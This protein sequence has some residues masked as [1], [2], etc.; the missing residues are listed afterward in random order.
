MT[1]NEVIAP[2]PVSVRII[3]KVRGLIAMA[4]SSEFPEEREAF[5]GKAQEMISRY[6][7]DAALLRDADPLAAT[8]PTQRN[9]EV[10]GK[11]SAARGSLINVVARA[12]GVKCIRLGGRKGPNGGQLYDLIGFESD[13]DMVEFLFVELDLYL[14]RE[15]SNARPDVIDNDDAPRWYRQESVQSYRASFAL[16]FAARIDER[17][18]VAKAAAEAAAKAEEATAPVV[19]TVGV[20][21]ALRNKDA[22]VAQ[23]YAKAYPRTSHIRRT[24]GSRS[25]YGAGSS[26]ANGANLNRSKAIR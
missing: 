22:A 6:E 5:F 16:G 20:A 24:V 23:A 18:T 1:T 13:I 21:L 25:G 19:R 14:A 4:N 11:Y 9:I 12:S 8:R 3:D 15:I 2:L 26:A 17:L 7:I 10:A